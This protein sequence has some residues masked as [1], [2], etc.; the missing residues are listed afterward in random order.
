M[1][2]RLGASV[3]GAELARVAFLV[4]VRGDQARRT[5]SVALPVAIACANSG[6]RGSSES[7]SPSDSAA[8][9]ARARAL[10]GGEGVAEVE[11]GEGVVDME[12]GEDDVER[13]D[14]AESGDA[15]CG[16]VE[17]GETCGDDTLSVVTGCADNAGSACSRCALCSVES[18][19]AAID[20]ITRTC[21]RRAESEGAGVSERSQA[22]C[23]ARVPCCGVAGGVAVWRTR[24]ASTYVLF[25]DR[26]RRRC[27]AGEC[28]C[29]R[30]CR[31]W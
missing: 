13:G 24:S 14:D 3:T 29:G 25:V 23:G 18:G 8:S 27:T 6:E 21:A 7:E 19:C 17:R 5:R 4:F 22:G 1:R 12:R 10:E 11:R 20:A 28:E 31:P 30:R 15:E 9:A 2:S 16:D 26:R